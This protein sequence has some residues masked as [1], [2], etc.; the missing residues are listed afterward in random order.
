[1]FVEGEGVR[2]AFMA[3]DFEAHGV[4]EREPL[5]G[6]A[7]EPARDGVLHQILIHRQP[8]V[9]GVGEQTRD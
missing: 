2:D 3:H 6:E 8:L 1:M 7:H 4:G 5:I 9:R